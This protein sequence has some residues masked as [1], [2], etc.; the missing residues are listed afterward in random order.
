MALTE[1][2]KKHIEEEEAYRAQIRDETQH[3]KQ[4]TPTP[5]KGM[6]GCLIVFLLFF[7]FVAIIII[8][9]NPGKQFEVAEKKAEQARQWE[10]TITPFS[11]YEIA[12]KAEDEIK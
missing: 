9:V 5:K 3:G 11:A 6:S 10:S 7:A 1:K 4:T 8:A 2:E 12:N